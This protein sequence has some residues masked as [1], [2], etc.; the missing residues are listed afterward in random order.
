MD[1]Y[2]RCADERRDVHG[3]AAVEDGVEQVMAMLVADSETSGGLLLAVAADSAAD[4][5]RELQAR[6]VLVSPVGRAEAASGTPRIR[7]EA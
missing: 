2:R 3:H 4:L 6:D 5:E 7:L 1:P